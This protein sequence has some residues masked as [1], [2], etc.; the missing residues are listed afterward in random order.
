MY[1]KEVEVFNKIYNEIF[2][3]KNVYLVSSDFDHF[4]EAQ[5]KVSS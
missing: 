1:S 4:N 3:K 2:K 5:G